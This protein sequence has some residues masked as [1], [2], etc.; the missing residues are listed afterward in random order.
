MALALALAGIAWLALGGARWHACANVGIT[1]VIAGAFGFAPVVPLLAGF[2]LNVRQ[3]LAATAFSAVAAFCLACCGS[4]DLTG[5]NALA[6]GTM[7]GA[8]AMGDAALALVASPGM[9][10]MTASWLVAAALGALLCGRGTRGVAA[11]GMAAATAVLV[12]GVVAAAHLAG[13]NF[14]DVAQLA[15]VVVAGIAMMCATGAG[16]PQRPVKREAKDDADIA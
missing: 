7:P 6:F 5:W 15:P 4:G 13:A 11:C 3:A 16:V 1:S 12:L 8:Q 2:F 14:P 9:W 10:A